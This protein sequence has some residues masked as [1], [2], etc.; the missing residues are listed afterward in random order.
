MSSMKLG[1]RARRDEARR[2]PIEPPVKPPE[3]TESHQSEEKHV[4]HNIPQPK[5]DMASE[6]RSVPSREELDR[7]AREHQHKLRQQ[8]PQ[9]PPMRDYL[10][11]VN[12]AEASD[13]V[14]VRAPDIMLALM[15]FSQRF[16]EECI[17]W[18]NIALYVEE[19]ETVE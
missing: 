15:K 18:M 1:L 14:V 12:D 2:S 4:E 3:F 7:M 11:M 6:Q 16:H 19:V 10:F 5:P 8:Q 9:M 17:D 13:K